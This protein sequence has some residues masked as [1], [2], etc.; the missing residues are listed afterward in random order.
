MLYIFFFIPNIISP[1]QHGSM[2]YEDYRQHQPYTPPQLTPTE[3]DRMEQYTNLL[4]SKGVYPYTWVDSIDKLAHTSLPP[5]NSFYNDLAEK[6]ISTSAYNHALRVW[7]TFEMQTF[8]E[9]HLWYQ[10]TDV[11]ILAD[12]FIEFRKQMKEDYNL[13][14]SRFFTMSGLALKAALRSSRKQLQLFTDKNMYLFGN[15]IPHFTSL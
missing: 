15:S 10:L 4:S 3:N 11:L 12:I 6:P 7:D 2:Q 1:S 13:D 8:K 5:I 9:Y 14:A